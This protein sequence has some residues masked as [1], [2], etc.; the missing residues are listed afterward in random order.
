MRFTKIT[1]V[2]PRLSLHALS[3]LAC[4]ALAAGQAHAGDWASYNH[5]NKRSAVTD[6]RISTP[7]SYTHLRAH[8]T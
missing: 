5:D 4:L 2:L 3:V 7:V 1:G 8:E 6:E